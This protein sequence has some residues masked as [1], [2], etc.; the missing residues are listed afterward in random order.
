MRSLMNQ[1]ARACRA[2]KSLA[3]AMLIAIIPTATALAA[4]TATN[5]FTG[6]ETSLASA[7][8]DVTG[9]YQGTYY[10]NIAGGRQH[11]NVYFSDLAFGANFDLGKIA[12]IHGGTIDFS[13]DARLGGFPQGVNDIT[14]SSVGFLGGA[15]PDN[16]AR[17]DFNSGTRNDTVTAR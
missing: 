16:R 7:G 9:Y 6:I 4:T 12:D 11:T 10:A 2:A 3:A 1:T 14:G 13:I 17:P 15:G 8:I 5:P